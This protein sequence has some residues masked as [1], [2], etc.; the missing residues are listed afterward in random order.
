MGREREEEHRYL[1]RNQYVAVR[2][3]LT[4]D[5][6]M[7]SIA[8]QWCHYYLLLHLYAAKTACYFLLILRRC[9]DAGVALLSLVVDLP[10][11]DGTSN[12]QWLAGFIGCRI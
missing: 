1:H 3:P 8:R 5:R 12:F 11:V 2:A 10:G 7:T 6:T 9:T 4:F